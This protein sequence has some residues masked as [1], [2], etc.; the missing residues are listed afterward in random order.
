[1]NTRLLA[2]AHLVCLVWL[3]TLSAIG[4]AAFQPAKLAEIDSAIETAIKERK[5]PGGVLWLERNG[6][7]YSKAYG[8]RAVVPAA[9]HAVSNPTS[10]HPPLPAEK[11]PMLSV[12]P[13]FSCASPPV[14]TTSR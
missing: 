8:Q 12:S 13:S 4:Q 3:W 9:D 5:C 1:M 14:T 2:W 11:P 7:I 6:V 10:D